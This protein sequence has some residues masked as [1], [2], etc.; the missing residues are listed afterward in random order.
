[1][2]IIELHESILKVES[3]HYNFKGKIKQNLRVLLHQSVKYLKIFCDR[4]LFFLENHL[5]KKYRKKLNIFL[6]IMM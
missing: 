3:T 1:M 6:I 5:I 2:N 4:L